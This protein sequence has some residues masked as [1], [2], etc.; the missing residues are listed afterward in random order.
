MLA[1]WAAY[2]ERKVQISFLSL[3]PCALILGTILIVEQRPGFWSLATLAGIMLVLAALTT[4]VRQEQSWEDRGIDFSEELRIDV[5]LTALGLAAGL[6]IIAAFAPYFSLPGFYARVASFLRPTSVSSP[7]EGADDRPFSWSGSLGLEAPTPPPSPFERVSLTGLPRQ[8]LLG[9]TP[10]LQEQLVMT[11]QVSDPAG[12]VGSSYY[13]RA[14]NYD[15]YN[16][17]GW[18]TGATEITSIKAQEPIAEGAPGDARQIRQ[19]FILERSSG[20]LVFS[21][22]QL[23][24]FNEPAQVAWRQDS[25]T[26]DYFGAMVNSNHYWS[27][28]SVPVYQPADLLNAPAELPEWVAE[29]YLDYQTAF[30]SASWNWQ[31]KRQPNI[32]PPMKRRWRSRAICAVFPTPLI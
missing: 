7:G 13:W 16:G 11:V 4:F 19:E 8:H 25:T 29:R 2:V 30:R 5:G 6:V 14:L 27:D 24:A 17:S 22:G 21:A 20:G 32:P 31:P 1:Q 23:S 9:I 18:Q 28:A 26:Q 10:D 12:E 3:L 15:T